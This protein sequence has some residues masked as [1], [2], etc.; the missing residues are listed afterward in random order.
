[1]TIAR[2]AQMAGVMRGVEH[3]HVRERGHSHAQAEGHR[4]VIAAAKTVGNKQY[5]RTGFPHHEVELSLAVPYVPR[6]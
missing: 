1:M 5:A 3:D 6:E 2:V 4:L